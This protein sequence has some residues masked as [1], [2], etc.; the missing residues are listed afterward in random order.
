MWYPCTVEKIVN[1]G[2]EGHDVSADLRP[3]L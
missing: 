1:D 2:D 3:M